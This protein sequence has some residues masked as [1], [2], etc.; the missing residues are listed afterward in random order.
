VANTG[1]Q[2]ENK[3]MGK[4]LAVCISNKKGVQKKP[5]K[6]G[7]IKEQHGIV[8]DAHAGS[9]THRQVSLLDKKSI[10]KMKKLGA[11][12]KDGDFG[13]NIITQDMNLLSLPIGSRLATDSG[14]VLEVT[15]IGKECH[16]H[17]AIYQQ[18]GT[19]I[20]PTEGIFTRVIKGGVI[21]KGDEIR[22][23]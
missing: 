11:E 4:I 5:V 9:D 8:G 15:Q 10:D 21:K 6:E 2:G 17:C 16:D 3:L 20:M 23:A 7:V 12:L 13:E 14:V 19:C 22:V 18:V 1:E